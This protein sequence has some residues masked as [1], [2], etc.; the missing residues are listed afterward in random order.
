MAWLK[1]R[2]LSYQFHDYR[3]AGITATKLHDWI[4]REGLEKIL[5]KKSTTWRSLS[6]AEQARAATP[7]GAVKLML[8]HHTLIKRPVVEKGTILIVGT[9]EKRYE[10]EL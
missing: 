5:N 4:S 7:D 8:E 9:D 10:A 1:K 6:P 3:V 2:K